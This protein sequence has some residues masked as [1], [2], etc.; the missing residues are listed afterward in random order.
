MTHLQQRSEAW[1][2]ARD[3]KVTC[4]NVGA[5][6]GLVSYTPRQKAYER[7]LGK[8]AFEG[9]DATKHGVLHEQDGINAYTSRTGNN[10]EETGLHQHN[11]YHWLAGSPDGLV[12][13]TGMVEVK[14]P[15]YNK[16]HMSIPDHYWLQMNLLL[17]ITDREWC[18][19]L[20]WSPN[21]TTLFRV[22]REPTTLNRLMPYLINIADAL[23]CEKAKIPALTPFELHTIKNIIR[24]GMVL[25]I[26][27]DFWKF[28]SG[29]CF[30]E[31]NNF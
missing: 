26:D 5:L 14:C 10:V 11:L 15:Y 28:D 17:E 29:T 7:A 24:E 1:L 31:A 22:Y 13:E 8:S 19:F 12:G 16:V 6:L 4:S 20:S 25:S 18:D 3:K 23:N 30:L 27:Y 2:R 9:N 21:A